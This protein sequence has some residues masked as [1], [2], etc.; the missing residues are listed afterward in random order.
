MTRAIGIGRI[1]GVKVEVDWTWFVVFFLIAWSLGAAILPEQTPGLSE[2]AY[3]AMAIAGTL[4]FFASLLLHELGHSV[5]ARREGM[6]IEGITLWLFGGVARFRGAFPSARA[7]LRIALAGPAITLLL[8]AAFA[9][10]AAADLPAAVDGVALW[11]AS[12]NVVLLIFNMLPGLPLDGGRVARAVIWELTGDF[13]RAT[14]L[15]AGAGQ[16]LSY[17][18]MGVGVA[19]TLL[20]GLASGI[21]LA[22]I[23]W[24]LLGA[25]RSEIQQ[26]VVQHHLGGMRVADLM[27]RDPVTVPADMSLARFLDEIVWPHRYTSY[28]VLNEAGEL[29]GLIAFR[30][31]AKVPREDLAL[32]RVRQHAIPLEGVMSVMPEEPLIDAMQEMAARGVG[33]ALVVADG[34]LVGLLSTTDIVRALETRR[35]RGTAEFRRDV[36]AAP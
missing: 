20:L 19:L 28:P 23:G 8:A 6:E 36:P 7:E 34:R 1:A 10:V 11:L 25:S 14:R 30:Q 21:W 32:H 27:V 15:A 33:R 2:G 9:M 31:L 24:F 18:F 4:V 5:Q 13:Q 22:I 16:V 12:I 17:V 29:A 26:A 35:A 3:W